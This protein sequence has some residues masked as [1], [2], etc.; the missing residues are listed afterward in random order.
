[1]PERRPNQEG[2]GGN[3]GDGVYEDIEKPGDDEESI[4][5]SIIWLLIYA[6]IPYLDLEY[7]GLL[8]R[9]PVLGIP[10]RWLPE[11]R[12]IYVTKLNAGQ[13]AT[14]AIFVLPIPYLNDTEWL[15]LA[16]IFLSFLERFDPMPSKKQYR[17]WKEK[18]GMD[19]DAGAAVGK[20]LSP[21][22]GKIFALAIIAV[23]G[24]LFFSGYGIILG[25]SAALS[26]TGINFQDE[27]HTVNSAINDFTCML[28]AT[29]LRQQRLNQSVRPGAED[30][31]ETFK[32]K[33]SE[34]TVNNGEKIDI[35][36]YG[37]NKT[38]PIYFQIQNPEYYDRNQGY[39]GIDAYGV[40]Y[41]MRVLGP[42]ATSYCNTTWTPIA[43]STGQRGELPSGGLA[44]MR[45]SRQNLANMTMANCNLMQPSLGISRNL[46]VQ[47]KY[48]FSSQSWVQIQ[49]MSWKQMDSLGKLPDPKKSKTLNTP[50]ESYINIGSP[51]TYEVVDGERTRRIVR[52]RVGFSTDKANVKYR[53]QP[54]EVKI[55]DLSGALEPAWK[56]E[57]FEGARC[58]LKKI[59]DNTYK[60]NGTLQERIKDI[61]YKQD[62]WFTMNSPPPI[63]FCTMALENPQS[64]SP[65]GETL[66][67]SVEVNYTVVL[68]DFTKR[69]SVWNTNCENRNCPM[70]LANQ[71][72]G[73]ERNFRSTCDSLW[74]IDARDGCVVRKGGERWVNANILNNRNLDKIVEDGET[75]FVATN[76]IP[77]LDD[78]KSQVHYPQTITASGKTIGRSNWGAIGL[79]SEEVSMLKKQGGGIGYTGE[80]DVEYAPISSSTCGSDSW[81]S[82]WEDRNG[83]EDTLFLACP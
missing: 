73:E 63:S 83:F 38:I 66:T 74:R 80:A 71:S 34:L 72:I 12:P 15:K 57:G 45:G 26:F 16:A 37:P 54:G 49:A 19:V 24:F 52:A 32:L 81:V 46:E 28:S 64:I 9:I 47:M 78:T 39:K 56:L 2:P 44:I 76:L 53:I 4:G 1:M 25:K 67:L 21:T 3:G 60:L 20:A 22:K 10:F 51:I 70:L 65:S 62:E 50:V 23:I 58:D 75:G 6:A 36:S 7:L 11:V 77:K 79:T 59:N 82:D 69:F 55:H 33:I 42:A 27:I 30:V 14:L 68:Q 40:K 61:Q 41:R 35:R 5:G 13:L 29:C 31:G 48:N 18:G 8:A 17:Q 43:G